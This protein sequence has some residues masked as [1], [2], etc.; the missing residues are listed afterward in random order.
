MGLKPL[1]LIMCTL[2]F[3]ICCLCLF[4]RD[5]KK[6]MDKIRSLERDITANETKLENLKVC[7]GSSVFGGFF[8]D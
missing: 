3:C 7:A 4:F 8:F 1:T 2:L 6:C 5:T